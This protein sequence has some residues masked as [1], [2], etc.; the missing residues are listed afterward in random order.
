VK[1]HAASV[2]PQHAAS[3]HAT[4][5]SPLRSPLSEIGEG[6]RG[7]GLPVCPFARLPGPCPCAPTPLRPYAL[8]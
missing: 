1:Q 5:G 3:L 8:D 6:V 4:A 7:R 2:H